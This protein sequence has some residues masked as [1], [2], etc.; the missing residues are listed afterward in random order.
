MCS[1]NKQDVGT[2]SLRMLLHHTGGLHGADYRYRI[3]EMLVL[4]VTFCGTVLLHAAEWR[5]PT[6]SN[7]RRKNPQQV[8]REPVPRGRDVS[9]VALSAANVVTYADWRRSQ[10]AGPDARDVVFCRNKCT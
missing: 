1:A 9:E 3:V 4:V 7:S 5:I 6:S 2:V 8:V 10:V